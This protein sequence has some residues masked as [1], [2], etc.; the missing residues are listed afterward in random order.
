MWSKYNCS[1][2]CF[3]A[4]SSFV[5]E[6]EAHQVALLPSAF[7]NFRCLVVD[8]KSDLLVGDIVIAIGFLV[9]NA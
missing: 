3:V 7:K 8:V 1:S 9:A 5:S 2:F 4:Y 6:V